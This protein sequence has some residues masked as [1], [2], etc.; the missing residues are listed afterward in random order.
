MVKIMAY[1]T[2]KYI[3]NR[4]IWRKNWDEKNDELS[5]KE[6][7]NFTEF[8]IIAFEFSDDELAAID[9]QKPMIMELFLHV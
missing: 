2:E 8:L 4:D 3:Y 6:K 7:C 1:Y 9:K 5:E